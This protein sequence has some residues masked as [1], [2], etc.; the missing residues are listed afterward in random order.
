MLRGKLDK[1]HM[2]EI[3]NIQNQHS[4]NTKEIEDSKTILCRENEAINQR[5]Q[6]KI[7][8]MEKDM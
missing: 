4:L 7:N 1:D 6:Q 3:Q 5:L 8:Q 2:Q